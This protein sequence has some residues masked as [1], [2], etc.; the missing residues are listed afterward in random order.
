MRIQPISESNTNLHPNPYLPRSTDSATA[1]KHA[2]L[3]SFEDCLRAQITDFETPLSTRR[4]ETQAI[5]SLWGH[6]MQSGVLLKSG[7]K[8]RARAKNSPSDT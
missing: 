8:L 3:I 7:I 6:Q 4:A 1:G 5:S 2:S